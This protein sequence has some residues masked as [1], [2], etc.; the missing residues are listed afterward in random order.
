MT[1][2]A[3]KKVI[4]IILC[5]VLVI[6]TNPFVSLANEE[7]DFYAQYSGSTSASWGYNP[8]CTFTINKIVGN[9]FRGSFSAQNIDP[10]SFSENVSG[11]VTST[12]EKF[13]CYFRVSF[14]NGRCYS[15]IIATV[16]PYEGRCE[17]LCDGSWH[18]V[19]F[20]MM[21]TRFIK[22][23][24]PN[25]IIDSPNYCEN[26]MVLSAKFSDYIYMMKN[27]SSNDFIDLVKNEEK[28][29]FDKNSIDESSIK[30]YNFKSIG[31]TDHNADNVAFA[32]ML[33]KLDD[34]TVDVIVVIRGT[35]KDE[36]QGNT[37]ITG[38][39]YDDK[40]T[41]HDNFNKAN[42]SIKP[43]I[44]KY[45]KKYCL[46]Y[47]NVNLIITGHSR[48]AA[49]ANLYAKEATD[50]INGVFNTS[51]PT[52]SSVTAYTF[53]TPNVEIHN[54]SMEN[55]DNIFNYCF[56]QDLI[57]TVPLTKPV[58]GWGYWKYGKTYIAS[59][60]DPYLKTNILS[61]DFYIVNNVTKIHDCLWKWPSVND[62]YNKHLF[63]KNSAK[64]YTT[65]YDFAH[66]ATGLLGSLYKK[67][68]GLNRLI[69]DYKKYEDIYPIVGTAIPLLSSIRN[70]DLNPYQISIYGYLV[71][72]ADKSGRC[73]PSRE[74]IAKKCNIKSVVT[75]DK[76]IKE[77]ESR[78]YIDKTKRY[79]FSGRGNLSNIYTINKI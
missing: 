23:I 64:D 47:D 56:L 4:L 79:D 11:L 60:T 42:E 20:E 31:T 14:Y 45:V 3:I 1:S 35:Y 32:I 33:R 66:S 58:A 12:E 26:D 27:N 19:D 61:D 9:R 21:G 51:I 59:L 54:E 40:C 6:S 63:A 55:Y 77:L 41:I 39:E 69:K 53:A 50:S 67:A 44:K 78:G 22:N 25:E 17:C 57:P 10:Y 36:W 37:E 73:Y 8:S 72:C 75:V 30:I 7:N 18:L 15:N 38:T 68:I 76:A 5:I 29:I 16:Y 46:D 71:R 70:D 49:V 74:T 62:Y 34:S 13:T 24:D 2:K 65:L 52:F 43:K 48:G 28:D